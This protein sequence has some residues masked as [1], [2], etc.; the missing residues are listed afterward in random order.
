MFGDVDEQAKDVVRQYLVW[1]NYRNTLNCFEAEKRQSGTGMMQNQRERLAQNGWQDEMLR[2][3]DRG[4]ART[5]FSLW[6][7]AVP[8]RIRDGDIEAQKLEF[9]L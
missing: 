3:F 4:E 1:H 8:P 2:A 5:V 6:D 9:Y 7:R